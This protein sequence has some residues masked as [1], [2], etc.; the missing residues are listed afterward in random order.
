M[1]PGLEEVNSS[2]QVAFIPGKGIA[3]NILLAQEVVSDYHKEKGKARCT[4]KVDLMKAY[5]SFNLENI[6]HY[7]HCFG[8][9]SRYI[10]WIWEC[11]T[12][13]S[14]SI[15]LNGTLVGGLRQRDPIS[16]YLF[17]LVMEGLSLLLEEAASNS[18]FS[19]HPKCSVIKLS[20]LCF[21]DDLLIFSAATLASARCCIG[22]LAEFEALLGLKANPSKSSVFLAGVT[23]AAKQ[24]LF[25]LLHIPERVLPVRYLSVSL[26]SKRLSAAD[27]DSLISKISSRIDSWLVRKLSF[28]GRLQLLSSVLVSLQM[29]WAQVFILPKKVIQLL[30]HKFNRFLWSGS[31]VKSKAK[32]SWE[33]LCFPKKKGG[34]GIKRVDVWNQASMLNHIWSLFAK[35]GSLWVA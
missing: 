9:P 21:A 32:V 22:A 23:F 11:I 19:Y 1:I 30:K 15:A 10:A 16:P 24:N 29:F 2:N 31:G 4:L 28:A 25:E 12:S 18:L 14:F 7:L 34:L 27:C 33:N 5:D 20:H 26:I 17:V 8:A 6:L 35:A 3:E 13:P